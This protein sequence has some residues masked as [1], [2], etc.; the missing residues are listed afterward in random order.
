MVQGKSQLPYIRIEAARGW[1]G[2]NLSE[3]WD[4]RELLYFLVWWDLKVR[5][6][7]T[8]IGIG[9]TV[10][11]PLVSMVIFTAIFGYLAKIPSD[12]IPYPLF[13]YAALLPWN[14]FSSAL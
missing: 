2:L 4:F 7:Q 1:F 11:Q 10:L 6:K 3:L 13:A 8:A 12:N 9:W 14:Y 5:Y